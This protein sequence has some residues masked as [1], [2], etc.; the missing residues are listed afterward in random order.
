M[1]LELYRPG[2]SPVHKLG[3]GWKLAA[4]IVAGT[5]LFAIDALSATAACLLAV[6]AFYWLAGFGARTLL[7]Q[8]RPLWWVFALI[9]GVQVALGNGGFGLL[10]VLRFTALLLLACLVTLT[11]RS[12]DMVDVITSA[13]SW[14]RPLGANPA[15]VGLTFSLALRF[16]PCSPRRRRRCARR[17]GRA[18]WTA[19][20]LP[21]PF[22]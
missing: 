21:R 8:L 4:L 13:V 11:T 7:A 3:A 16:L 15:K 5:V 18:A 22:P 10:L 9:L 6:G 1:T 17:S 2:T 20:C 14:L 12:S 19:M